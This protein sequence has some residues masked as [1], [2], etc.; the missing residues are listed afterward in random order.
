MVSCMADQTSNPEKELL[1]FKQGLLLREVDPVRF[2]ITE[3]RALADTLD[4]PLLYLSS[5]LGGIGG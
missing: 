1:R 3:S 4:A 5:R 2:N